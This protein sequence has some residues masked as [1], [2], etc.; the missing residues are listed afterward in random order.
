MIYSGMQL[1]LDRGMLKNF[2]LHMKKRIGDSV[3]MR[4]LT[5]FVQYITSINIY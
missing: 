2:V 5:R 3:Y 4:R 1:K